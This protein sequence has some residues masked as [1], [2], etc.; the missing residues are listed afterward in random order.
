LRLSYII[1][2]AVVLS[3]GLVGGWVLAHLGLRPV[4]RLTRIAQEIVRAEDLTRRV[5]ASRSK[6]EIG[7]LA[8]TFNEMLDRLQAIFESQQRFLAEAAHELRTPLS[9]MLGNVDLL[10]RFGENAVRRQETLIALQRTG[11]HVAR[12]LDD[13][14]LLA[15]AEAGWHLQLQ[16]VA[17]DDIFIEAYEGV[18]PA[19]NGVQVQLQTCE[20]SCV[21]GDPDRLRQVFTNLIDNAVKYSPPDSVV[22]LDLW[23]KDGR[24]WVRVSNAG[25]G[26]SPEALPQVFKP[27]F[28]APAQ[29]RR[30]GAGLGLTIVYWIVREHRGEVIIESRPD[31]GTTVTL[32]LP[33]YSS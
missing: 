2:A 20:P 9:S 7:T 1:G 3:F 33:E 27:F 8:T 4:A 30:P 14:L 15:Q 19:V 11:R 25:P 23:R 18:Q 12:L 13:L 29:A 6:D 31:H 24:V 32:S 5:S 10:A 28:R 26:I 17:V 16:P 21:L 22:S